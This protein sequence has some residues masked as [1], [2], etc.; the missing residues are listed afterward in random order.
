[1]LFSAF[2]VAFGSK[3]LIIARCGFHKTRGQV[4]DTCRVSPRPAGARAMAAGGKVDL[5][6]VANGMGHVER[7]HLA[8]LGKRRLLGWR[9]GVTVADR[10]H[11]KGSC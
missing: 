3:N 1:M 10:R 2:R 5:A 7:A 8:T 4:G 9:H 6:H 11:G